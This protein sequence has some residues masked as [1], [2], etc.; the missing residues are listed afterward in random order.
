MLKYFIKSFLSCQL[1]IVF[2]LSYYHI[3]NYYTTEAA[4]VKVS[5]N[6]QVFNTNEWLI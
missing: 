6:I 3:N 4:L 1:S 5:D 2:N